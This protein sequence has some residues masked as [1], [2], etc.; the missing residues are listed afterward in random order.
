MRTKIL[1]LGL[2]C[3]FVFV[4]CNSP[5]DPEIK[6]VL[7]PENSNPVVLPIINYFT[8]TYLQ[9]NYFEF[10]WEVFTSGTT[11]VGISPNIGEVPAV[12][13]REVEVFETTTYTL[14]ASNAAGTITAS[15]VVAPPSI[16][17]TDD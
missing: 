5:A 4:Y 15:C 16:R 14:T 1:I 9:G 17:V 11:S 13:T 10:S 3:L 2:I 7:S 6:K 8:A 12:G